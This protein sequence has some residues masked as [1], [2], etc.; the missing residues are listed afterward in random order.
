LPLSDDTFPPRT[1]LPLSN[2]KFALKGG[3]G[4]ASR[5]RDLCHPQRL[6]DDGV[7]PF[8][9]PLEVRPVTGRI[10]LNAVLFHLKPGKLGLQIFDAGI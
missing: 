3:R 10:R 2:G 6:G 7:A 8:A 9:L 1:I 4:F 5:H